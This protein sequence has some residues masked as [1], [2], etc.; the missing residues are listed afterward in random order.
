VPLSKAKM[1]AYMKERRAKAVK[2][3]P[4]TR[5]LSKATVRAMRAAGIDPEKVEW[6]IAESEDHISPS[7]YYHLVRDRDAIKAHLGWHHDSKTHPDIGT[8]VE[9][10][11][12]ELSKAQARITLLEAGQVIREA[13]VR[14]FPDQEVP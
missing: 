4:G 1:R 14:Y 3:L 5:F 6:G 10:L 2:P 11:Q 8:V 12:V 7:V 13:G 9:R